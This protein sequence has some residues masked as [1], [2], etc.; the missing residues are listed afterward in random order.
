[1]IFYLY[2]ERWRYVGSVDAEVQPSMSTSIPI[3]RFEDGQVPQW[4]GSSWILAA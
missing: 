2:D 1:M 4:T 3:P